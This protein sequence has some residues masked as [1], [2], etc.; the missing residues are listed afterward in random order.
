MFPSGRAEFKIKPALTGSPTPSVTMGIVAVARRAAR[1]A[2]EPCTTITS[3]GRKT[4]ST[5]ARV[6]MIDVVL[7]GSVLDGNVLTHDV[8]KFAQAFAESDPS[9]ARPL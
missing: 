5:A 8:A 7:R 4:S 9:W 6:K 1:V 2:G 3:V